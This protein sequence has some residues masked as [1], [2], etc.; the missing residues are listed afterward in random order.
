MGTLKYSTSQGYQTSEADVNIL[1]T[2]KPNATVGSLKTFSMFVE[3]DAIIII[4][5]DESNPITV[6]S[7][8]GSNYTD[9]FKPIKSLKF[10]DSGINYFVA[11][12]V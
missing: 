12:G 8:L 1:T 7:K 6:T 3:S 9:I 4:D 5:D 10:K 2:L 11:Y